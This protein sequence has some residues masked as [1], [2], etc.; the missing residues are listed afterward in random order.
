MLLMLSALTTAFDIQVIS[1][2]PHSQTCVYVH[3]LESISSIAVDDNLVWFGTYGNG[4]FRYDKAGDSWSVYNTSNSGLAG[5]YVASV[6]VDG[7]FVWF[8]TQNEYGTPG[9]LGK[10]VCRYDKTTDSWITFDP[11][12]SG[13]AGT[14]VESIVVDGD[15]IWFATS[16][17]GI[18]LYNKTC[19]TWTTY[20][21]GNSGLVN[22]LVI[23]LVIDGDELWAGTNGQYTSN[24]GL[25]RFNQTSGK[26]TTYTGNGLDYVIDMVVD[27]NVIWLARFEGDGG[28]TKY[29][30]TSNTWA[31]YDFNYAESVAVDDNS[32]WFGT[33]S[34][35]FE[36]IKENN[37]WI[38]HNS[39]NSGLLTDRINAIAVDGGNVWF[40]CYPV[41]VARYDKISGDWVC[42]SGARVC[43]SINILSP[44][45]MS[46]SEFSVPLTFAINSIENKCAH[47]TSWI[48]YSLDSQTNITIDG[49]ITL[50]DLTY[51]H[52]NVIVYANDTSG[53]MGSSDKVYFTISFLGDING[54]GIID[55][56]DMVIVGIV[57][58]SRLGDSN[59]NGQA[60]LY[61][62][63]IIDIFDIIIVANH[64]GETY[65]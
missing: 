22:D 30:K 1:A 25:S 16:I 49:N 20:N 45:N 43:P 24:D 5:D 21:S 12:N 28:G 29:N 60:D 61:T 54:D 6:A 42:W 56:Y 2:E 63:G 50:T 51:G 19:D 57:F 35:V 39:T 55:V 17:G 3:K 34:G 36:Y 7:D 64:F 44:Q 32:T 52:H 9:R 8:G 58:G 53:Y 10:G 37:I 26:W 23:S 11:M 40:S 31:F 41:G 4:V 46:Y 15:V 48:G 38:T 47:A 59:W 65:P 62:D 27:G 18:S 13:L 33:L 14:N